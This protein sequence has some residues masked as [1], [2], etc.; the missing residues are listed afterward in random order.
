MTCSF[1]VPAWE[2]LQIRVAV[3]L[4]LPSAAAREIGQLRCAAMRCAGDCPVLRMAAVGEPSADGGG[5]APIPR[6]QGGA[7]VGSPGLT[8]RQTVWG[9]SLT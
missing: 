1:C 3:L 2:L 5:N 7:P 9:Y 4:R 8:S 6:V